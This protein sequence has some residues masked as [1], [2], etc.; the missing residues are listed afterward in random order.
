VLELYGEVA[1]MQASNPIYHPPIAPLP[2]WHVPLAL[3]LWVV[4]IFLLLQGV[5]FLK[6]ATREEG[7]A[8]NP[9]GGIRLAWSLT[10]VLVLF[11]YFNSDLSSRAVEELIRS[12]SDASL[13]IFVWRFISFPFKEPD[14][15]SLALL[16]ASLPIGVFAAL[17]FGIA[18]FFVRSAP[19]LP[20]SP[21]RSPLWLLVV[22]VFNFLQLAGSFATLI[23]F[24]R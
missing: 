21:K 12:T 9:R 16:S 18:F 1:C 15:F 19:S 10:V 6:W 20:S 22:C 5:A 4:S 3:G 7:E 2:L 24:F 13:F 11:F 23:E 17:K 14:K 8:P